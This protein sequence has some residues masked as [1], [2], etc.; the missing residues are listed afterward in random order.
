VIYGLETGVDALEVNIYEKENKLTPKIG[1]PWSE[2]RNV[3]FNNPFTRKHLILHGANAQ[4]HINKRIL[5]LSMGNNELY[6]WMR[7]RRPDSTE[8]QQMPSVL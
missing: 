7:R 1:F 3:S 5:A 2:I 8:V 4:L 6:K